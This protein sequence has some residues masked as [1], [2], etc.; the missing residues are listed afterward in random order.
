MRSSNEPTF[1]KT[2]P[3]ENSLKQSNDFIASRCEHV[4]QLRF[5]NYCEAKCEFLRLS[6][7][8]SL[9][10]SPPPSP[11]LFSEEQWWDYRVVGISCVVCM[12]RVYVPGYVR[13]CA[14][15]CMCGTYTFRVCAGGIGGLYVP[16]VLA[17]SHV[18]LSMSF[19]S[20][21]LSSPS[22]EL[23]SLCHLFSP[24]LFGLVFFCGFCFLAFFHVDC[25]SV[26]CFSCLGVSLV[27]PRAVFQCDMV[28]C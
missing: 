7:W 20:C 14:D 2:P 15:A 21:F 11:L 16:H 10:T 28:P 12:C 18:V 23:F 3:P 26:M 4:R 6:A 13:V 1:T 27:C 19:L 5:R 8:L 24:C 25:A 22:E 9:L 17:D